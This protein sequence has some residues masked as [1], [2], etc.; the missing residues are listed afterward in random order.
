MA[1]QAETASY[2]KSAFLAAMSHEIRTPLNGVIGMTGLLLDTKLS[3]QQREYIDTIRVSGEAL[4][5]VINDILDFSKIESERMELDRADF[6]LYSLVQGTVDIVSSQVQRKGIALG[7]YIEPDVPEWVV[8]DA[9]RIRQVTTNLLGNAVKF[10]DKGEISIKVKTLKRE[11][12]DDGDNIILLFEV[13]DT[14]IGI[15]P[16]VRE[17]L[18]MPFSQGDVSTSRKYGGTGLG[19]VISKRLIEMMGGTI[20]VDSSPGRG[21][22]FWFT[23]NLIESKEAEMKVE[24][25]FPAEYKGKRILCV[26][27]NSINREIV[28][29]HSLNWELECDLASNAAEGLSM[30]RHAASEGQPYTL[31]IIDHIMP[32]MSGFEM[33]EIIK[34]LKD[35]SNTPVIILSSLGSSLTDEEM[36]KYGISATLMKPLTTIRLYETIIDVFSGISGFGQKTLEIEKKIKAH[37]HADVK[38]LLA[39]DN[40]INQLVAQR[41]LHR[42]GY[43]ADTVTNGHEAVKAATSKDYDLILM[44]CQM[45]ELDGYAATEEI[46][47]KE[48]ISKKHSTIIAMTAHALKG[49]KEKCIQAGMD[50]YLTKPI[51]IQ[52]FEN[53]LNKW[54]QDSDGKAHQKTQDIYQV[55]DTTN[56]HV[57]NDD[58]QSEQSNENQVKAIDMHRIH[59]IFGEDEILIK[60]FID[61]FISSTDDLLTEISSAISSKNSPETKNLFHRLK[62]SA[63]NSGMIIIYDLCLSA[64]KELE[65]ADWKTL[66]E[67]YQ[68]IIKQFENIKTEAVK[69]NSNQ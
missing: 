27:D 6:N 62:G 15:T 37:S 30:M 67:V 58:V 60:Q 29:K 23:I 9:Q 50:D 36:R 3:S 45:P 65:K 10:T 12:H 25:S 63:G 64:E 13:I 68:T 24:Y 49:D 19:L 61:L 43:S 55:D 69:L 28:K 53:M 66:D 34:N 18:F 1:A 31:V 33:I 26:D 35:I 20:D 32:G 21:S 5:S 57:S 56:Q 16:E 2:A 40:S 7:V 52:S 22:R 14:G 48:I 4:L 42:L 11:A 59:E 17:R 39:E 54:L 8:G 41:I 46:R 47:K 44:D 38:I 51:D